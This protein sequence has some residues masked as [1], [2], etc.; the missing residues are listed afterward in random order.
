MLHGRISFF[1]FFGLKDVNAWMCQICLISEV[2]KSAFSASSVIQQQ[3]KK[4][5]KIKKSEYIY[6]RMVNKLK[7]IFFCL[8]NCSFLREDVLSWTNYS[9][10]REYRRLK[11]RRRNYSHRT[12]WKQ[13]AIFPTSFNCWGLPCAHPEKKI[14]YS[15]PTAIYFSLPFVQTV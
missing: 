15:E 11:K 9:I 12:P 10:E 5:K 8:L 7:V 14:K 13:S 6:K 4:K 3:Y 1:F 2:P